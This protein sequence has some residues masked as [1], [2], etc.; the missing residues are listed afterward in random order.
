MKLEAT[1]RRIAAAAGTTAA[2]VAVM[3]AWA[4]PAAAAEWSDTSIG[5]R[6]GTKFREPF[7]NQNITKNILNLTHVS[8]YKYGTNF[9][10]VDM[11]MSDDKDPSTVG[12]SGAQEAYVVYRNTVALSKVTGKEYKYGGFVRDFGATF[13]FD[14]NT[15]NDVGYASKKRMLVL[16][17]TVMFDVPGF[18]NMSVL[19]LRESNAPVGHPSRYTYKSHPALSTAWGIPIGSSAFSFEGFLLNIASKGRDE[20]GNQTKPETNFDA[21]IMLDVG[22]VTGAAPKG[23]FKVGFEYQW[24]KNKF[25]NDASGAAGSG[26]FAKTPM[27]RAEYHF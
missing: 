9:F 26:A 20:F 7:N 10:N 8:G 23:T 17:P 13:G 2:V 12:G 14:W 18:L 5:W 4:G 24:W 3:G 21:Q 11:L 16:G 27:I 6:H 15:K 19:I 22:M 1:V 25:G